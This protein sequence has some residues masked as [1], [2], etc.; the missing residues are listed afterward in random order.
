MRLIVAA[1]AFIGVAGTNASAQEIFR[2]VHSANLPTAEILPQGSWLF[3]VSHRSVTP[4]SNGAEDLWGL[5]GP[6]VNRLGLAYSAHDRVVLGILRSNVLDNTELNVKAGLW[7]GGSATLPIKIAAMGGVSWNTDVNVTP[8]VEDNEMQAYGQ[9]IV[10]T[11]IGERFA[12]G[13]VPTFLSNPR[14]QDADADNA[15]FVGVNGQ[16]YL[17]PSMSVLVEWVAG[18]GIAEAPYDPITF[19]FEFNT[20]GHVFKLLSTNQ[21]RMNPAQIVAGAAAEF[22]PDAWLFGFNI[23]RLLPF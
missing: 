5:D 13:A 16:V 9:L 21:S 3:E 20:G 7:S 18:E 12:I 10:N 2:S 17:T 1:L 6:M 14:L 23:T 4:F 11:L 15:F 8:T 22:E 19:G